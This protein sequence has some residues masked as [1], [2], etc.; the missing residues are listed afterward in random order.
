MKLAAIAFAAV[1]MAYGPAM[2]AAKS[3]PKPECGEASWYDKSAGAGPGMSAAHPSLPFGTKV[4]VEN[5]DNGRTATLEINDRGPF[6][7]GRVIDVS[8]AAA[9]QLDFVNAGVAQVRI[10]TPGGSS[11]PACR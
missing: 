10:T 11:G 6:T 2:S 7:G 9:E 5:L 8:R 1:I 4:V 3:A